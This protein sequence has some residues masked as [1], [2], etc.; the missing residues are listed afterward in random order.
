MELYHSNI[1]SENKLQVAQRHLMPV[2]CCSFAATFTI[3]SKLELV[4]ARVLPSG[5]MSL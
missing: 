5:A 4:S 1:G 2:F 3:A